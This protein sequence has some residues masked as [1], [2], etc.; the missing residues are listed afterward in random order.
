MLILP[1][2]NPAHFGRVSEGGATCGHFSKLFFYSWKA[3]HSQAVAAVCWN[4]NVSW[5]YFRKGL[6][7]LGGFAAKAQ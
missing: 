3:R 2:D 4:H 5:K 6:T 7:R 1:S